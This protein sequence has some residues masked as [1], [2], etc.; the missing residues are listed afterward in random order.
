M[1][2]K[3]FL[4]MFLVC[5]YL[6]LRLPYLM[7]IPV[8]LD[9]SIHIDFA[10]SAMGGNWRAGGIL[11]KW[12]SIQSYGMFMKLFTDSLFVSRIL[13]LSLGLVNVGIVFA[14]GS[15]GTGP[16]RIRRGVFGALMY[17]VLP[18][19]VFYDRLALADQFQTTLLGFILLFS[20]RILDRPT[21]FN[22]SML[23]FVILLS[24]LFK[25]SGMFFLPIPIII[26]L[27]SGDRNKGRFSKLGAL[28]L[29]YAISVPVLFFFWMLYF[30]VSETG[31]L[32]GIGY[33]Y[34]LLQIIITN[35]QNT[36]NFLMS[37]FTPAV[38]I[39]IASGSIIGNYFCSSS[40]SRRRL[41]AGAG[42]FI[43]LLLPYVLLFRDWYPRYH[44]P[45]LIPFCLMAGE[46]AACCLNFRPKKIKRVFTAFSRMAP[47]LFLVIAASQSV[48]MLIK[49]ETYPKLGI[50]QKQYI[51]GWASGYG[52]EEAV[53]TIA[54][55]ST[56]YSVRIIVLRSSNWD[57]PMGVD[58]Y[59]RE[60]GNDVE[61]MILYWD[62]AKV[63]AH[64]SDILSYERP[65]YLLFNSA[66]PY[67]GD[68][69]IIECILKNFNVREIAHFEK[70]DQQRGLKL[71]QISLDL[72]E[73]R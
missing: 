71:W 64:L 1:T 37:V 22:K 18:F 59:Y 25:F 27:I 29:P 38:L 57:I 32:S 53:R 39:G 54:R 56:N 9:E 60:L 70:P 36:F 5:L 68:S 15:Y 11:G 34:E 51:T 24:P 4:L 2:K 8:F 23:G 26:T 30:P 50:I 45:L 21:A 62:A 41:F 48:Q 6:S 14:L 3:V 20:F 7:Q 46:L 55:I 63:E 16:D 19:S 10:K 13:P 17:I 35:A 33:G 72:T 40:A 49:P 61:R 42:V 44:L 31:K 69:E 65:T 47:L 12:L 58:V 73:E 66:Y 43:Y 52:L 67:R 28:A